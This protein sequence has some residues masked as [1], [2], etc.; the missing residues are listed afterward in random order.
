M[1]PQPEVGAALR[2]VLELG[3]DDQLWP[4]AS[5]SLDGGLCVNCHGKSELLVAL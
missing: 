3:N 1:C 5:G 4:L 2:G